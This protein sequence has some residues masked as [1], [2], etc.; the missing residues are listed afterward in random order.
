MLANMLALS[1]LASFSWQEAEIFAYDSIFRY[2]I[3]FRHSFYKEKDS[4]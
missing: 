3:L 2:L 4:L 1:A